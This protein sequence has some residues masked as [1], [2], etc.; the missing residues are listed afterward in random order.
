MSFFPLS[1]TTKVI[2]HFQ[3]NGIDEVSD[4]LT[5]IGLEAQDGIWYIKKITD[6]GV[7]HASKKNN[8]SVSSYSDAWTSRAS[9]IY[10]DFIDAF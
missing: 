2:D 7:Q 9:L 4:T 10:G 1:Q 8:E 5:Y 3:V 6:T